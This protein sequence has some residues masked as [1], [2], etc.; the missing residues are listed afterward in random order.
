MGDRGLGKVDEALG[1]C[2]VGRSPGE[3]PGEQEHLGDSQRK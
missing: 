1:A 2:S 3:S